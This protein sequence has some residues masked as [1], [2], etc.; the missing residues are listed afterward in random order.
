MNEMEL[1]RRG[2]LYSL[3]GVV[4]WVKSPKAKI[5]SLVS[6]AASA[7][8]PTCVASW[9][10]N[11]AAIDEYVNLTHAAMARHFASPEFQ[12][13]IDEAILGWGA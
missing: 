4:A 7:I 1:N 11:Q 8:Q 6:P 13:K 5:E 3:A 12:L 10:A 2:F 9:S